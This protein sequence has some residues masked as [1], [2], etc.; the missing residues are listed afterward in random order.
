MILLALSN[1]NLFLREPLASKRSG[2]TSGSRPCVG[3]MLPWP[4]KTPRG[5]S[6]A[7]NPSFGGG[8]PAG[9]MDV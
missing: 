1:V 5:G 9:K 8:S 7:E 2:I 6:E 4:E 3:G